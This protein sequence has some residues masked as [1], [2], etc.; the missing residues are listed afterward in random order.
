MSAW[1]LSNA[2]DDL[3]VIVDVHRRHTGFDISHVDVRDRRSCFGRAETCVGNLLRRNRQM[4]R[5]A[6]QGLVSSDSAGDN[7]LVARLVH[8]VLLL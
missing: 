2:L 5:H 1:F 4:W 3:S 6:R 7:D 8:C